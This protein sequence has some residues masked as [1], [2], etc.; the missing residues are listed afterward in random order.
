MPYR[1]RHGYFVPSAPPTRAYRPETWK[2]YYET[3]LE[4]DEE[5]EARLASLGQRGSPYGSEEST[6]ADNELVDAIMARQEDRADAKSAPMRRETEGYFEHLP[7]MP[8]PLPKS[9]HWVGYTRPENYRPAWVRPFYLACKEGRLDEVQ[10]WIRDKKEILRPIGLRDGLDCAAMGN[11]VHV[12]RYLLEAVGVTLSGYSVRAACEN[13][14][15][16]LFQLFI[17]HGYHP[18]Q[19]VPSR[20]GH[21]GTALRHCLDNEAIVRFLLQNGADP[22]AAPFMDR[23]N[24]VYGE[25]TTAPMDR[26]SGLLLDTAVEKH[27]FATVQMLLEY[28]ANPKY[29]RPLV[30]VVRQRADN[31]WTQPGSKEDWRP[32]MEMLL[33]YGA[34]IDGTAWNKGTALT[35]AVQAKRWDIVE[36][37]LE[38]GADPR[39]QTPSTSGTTKKN[40][41]YAAAEGAGINWEETE[42]TS[43]YLD[44]LCESNVEPSCGGCMSAPTDVEQNPL[45]KIMG[46]LR[47]R[48]EECGAA[49]QAA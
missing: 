17:Q 23:R 43:R 12:A 13:R 2:E 46:K 26:T 33:S 4:R 10:S 15:L 22:N 20:A 21:F 7:P 1:S 30:R 19:Q 16:P 31:L 14:S 8:P 5:D 45:V 41:F 35:A 6:Q 29:S 34:R 49:D 9:S 44:F 48:K 36:F 40:S 39:V 25:R 37:L 24:M 38:R 27:T 11:Q 32:L 42:E 18:N 47:A 3:V 28:G